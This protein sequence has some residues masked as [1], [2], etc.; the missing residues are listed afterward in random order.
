M[1]GR[2]DIHDQALSEGSA[3]TLVGSTSTPAVSSGP[4][5]VRPDEGAL[6]DLHGR[7]RYEARA[8]LGRGGMGEVQLCKDLRIGRDIAMKVIREGRGSR[9]DAQL[10]FLREARVQAQLEHPSIVPV[11]D[12]GRDE[13]EQI[14]FT[15]KRIRGQSLD[16]VIQR[17]QRGEATETLTRRRLLA[18]FAQVCMAVDYAHERGVLHRD[19]KPA[20]IMLGDYGEVYVLDWG[21][22]KIAGEPELELLERAHQD[23][24]NLQETAAGEVLGTPGYIAPEQLG[25]EVD[26]RSDVYAL[27]AILFEILALRR[28]HEGKSAQALLVSTLEGPEARPSQRS[29]DRDVPPELEEICVRATALS[30]DDRFPSARAL[31]DAIE[32]FLDGDRDLELRRE[33]AR[34]H[35]DAAA[36]ATDRALAGDDSARGEAMREVGH[37]LGLEPGN[38]VAM[39]SFARLLENPPRELP[40]EAAA[41]VDRANEKQLRIGARN[42]AFGYLSWFLYM[43]LLAWMGIRDWTWLAIAS[44]FML[45]AAAIDFYTSFSKTWPRIGFVAPVIGAVALSS[46]YGLFGAYVFLPTVMVGQV[47][48]ISQ[49]PHK[50]H[51]LLAVTAGCLAVAI[52]ALLEWAGLLPTATVFADNAITIVPTMTEFPPLATR[53]VLLA[54]SLGLIVTPMLL[55]GRVR[56]SLTAAELRIQV[57]AWHLRQLVSTSPSSPSPFASRSGLYPA[58]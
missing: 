54:A 50:R 18:T 48:A 16:S 53:V 46:L 9:S 1:S 39:R 56:D 45:V 34:T 2:D 58:V 29:V 27:G 40:P 31:H 47:V 10:R 35:A 7:E 8:L 36:A 33:Y 15:M 25:G 42:G 41:A 52:P 19:L 43:P 51:R 6:H 38:A 12:L 14:Y 11:Y 22:A 30:P 17:L 44:G 55:I 3:E 49:S 57:Q 20:N 5:P 37:A 28:L 24:G 23:A 13:D 21:L 26:R 4:S 32:S